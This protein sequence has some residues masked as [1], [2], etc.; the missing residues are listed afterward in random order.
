MTILPMVASSHAD[1]GLMEK[2]VLDTLLHTYQEL[3]EMIHV[4]SEPVTTQTFY[5]A[6]SPATQ[7]D[8][9]HL[10]QHIT[11]SRPKPIIQ[12]INSNAL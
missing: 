10:R 1:G 9:R 6:M 12:Q 3:A 11:K 5:F 2:A 7:I 4:S 8:M